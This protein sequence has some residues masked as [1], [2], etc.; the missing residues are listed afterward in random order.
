MAGRNF[1]TP[2]DVKEIASDVLRHRL[3][4]SY[5]AEAENQSADDVLK[6]ILDAIPVPLMDSIKDVYKNIRRIQI[7]TTRHVND[8]FAGMYHSAFKGKGLE[9]E[10][11]REYQQ[12]DDIRSIDWNVTAR[13]QTPYVKNFK[14]ERELTVML[15]VD[16]S[17]SSLFSHTKRLKSELIAEIGALLAFSAIKNQDKVGLLLYT[18]EVELY[19]RPKKGVRH[20]LRVIRE[21]LLFKPQHTGTNI[22]KALT[23]LGNVQRQRVICFLI[24]DFLTDNNFDHEATLIS[25]RHELIAIQVYDKYEK[26]FPDLGLVQ[27]RDLE[28]KLLY[29]IDSSDPTV[30]SHYQ[31]QAEKR[32]YGLKHLMNKLGA[33]F[34]SIASD[35]SYNKALL[36]FFKHR[37]QR[38]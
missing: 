38:R 13:L 11:V 20:V 1:V 19:L 16:I 34:I 28:S 5:E 10:D 22:Q 33:G 23:Y 25:K 9:F 3:R 8:L 35:E 30:Q 2:Q 31:Q 37:R 26:Q 27:L 14:E 4:L 6:H 24:S 29:L 7:R 36:Q 21:L 18:N 15:V 32:Q 12:G 17:A